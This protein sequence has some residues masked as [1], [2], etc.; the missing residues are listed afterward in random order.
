MQTTM[1]KTHVESFSHKMARLY[2]M[3]IAAG[4]IDV[5]GGDLG[6]DLVYVSPAL[7]YGGSWDIDTMLDPVE[8]LSSGDIEGGDQCDPSDDLACGCGMIRGSHLEDSFDIAD[9]IP[10]DIDPAGE[11]LDFLPEDETHQ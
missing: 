5:Y 7:R 3:P 9:L 6:N 1:D 8:D 10:D 2:A 11:Y 4:R